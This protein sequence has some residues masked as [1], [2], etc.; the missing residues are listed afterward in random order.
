MCELYYFA[1]GVLVVAVIIFF[2]HQYY[3]QSSSSEPVPS[4][5][6]IPDSTKNK[7]GFWPGW[8]PRRRWFGRGSGWFNPYWYGRY[9]PYTYNPYYPTYWNNYSYYPY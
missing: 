4:P 1:A 3:W 9:S 5:N 7:E 6:T 2:Y 8:G